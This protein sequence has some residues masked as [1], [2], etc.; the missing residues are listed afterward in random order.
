MLAGLLLQRTSYIAIVDR[1]TNCESTEHTVGGLPSPSWRLL[2]RRLLRS[3]A[4]SGLHSVCA[5]NDNRAA[6]CV[7]PVSAGP[8]AGARC[9]CSAPALVGL[10]D[11]PP[12][13]AVANPFSRP[14]RS[15]GPR[16]QGRP[17]SA[18]RDWDRRADAAVRRS[19]LRRLGPVRPHYPLQRPRRHDAADS[20]LLTRSSARRSPRISHGLPAI[21]QRCLRETLCNPCRYGAPGRDRTGDLP[22]R[23]RTLY[24]LSYRGV[25]KLVVGEG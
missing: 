9:Y 15:D 7:R 21:P 13:Q 2:P 25:C 22:L 3:R 6:G 11:H 10:A 24:P 16:G 18:R 5:W 8:R 4:T 12:P 23:R 14:S 1:G 20:F 17:P 19:T